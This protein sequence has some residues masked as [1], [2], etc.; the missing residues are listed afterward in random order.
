[1]NADTG[2]YEPMN[3]IRRA[4]R[5]IFPL[6][7][8]AL[9]S[10]CGGGGG[11]SNVGGGDV[12]N[13]V[14]NACGI[15]AVSAAAV[16][17]PAVASAAVPLGGAAL[18]TEPAFTALTFDRPIAMKQVEGDASC[19]FVA[20]QP[21]RV[22]AFENVSDVSK[23]SA[24]I[25]ISDRVDNGP[26]EAGLLGMAFHPNFTNNLQVFLSYTGDNGGQLTSY[27]SRFTSSDGGAT[28]DPD[29]E[30]ILLSLLQPFGNHNGG[31]IAFG[32][33]GYLYIG[34]GDGGAGNDPGERAQNTM[35]LY[36]AMLRIDVDT[37][38]PYAIPG[39][40]PFAGNALC[41]Q[42]FGAADCPE[43]Y[44]WGLRNPWR[45]SFD[46][47]TG[48]LWLGD[49]G[50]SAFEE[51]DIIDLGGNYGWPFFEA[52]LCNQNAPMVDCDF[53]GLLP[54]T[55]YP[56]AV[57]RAVTGGYVYHGN[58]IPD[59][60]GVYVYA[61]Y[62][63]GIVFQYFDSGGG[64]IIES[65]TNTALTISSFGQATDGELYLFDLLNGKIHKL[66]AD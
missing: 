31:N 5:R 7:A 22:F 11:E 32:P 40:N 23:R 10:A 55:E 8:L 47:G 6:L 26:N 12:N 45:W 19:W 35:N 56:R 42:G 15:E 58:D 17:L 46:S 18:T 14:N 61:D 28:L 64:N 50:Q 43:L 4:I 20:E 39:D 25:D 48:D 21:G 16:T 52:T 49:V 66:V 36:G 62:V 2:Y 27:V 60:I 44:A 59:L 9:L 1:M 57:G 65:T 54:V 29:S 38:V 41:S 51:I 63:T 13:Y 34:F 53:I 3:M 33:D 30:E 24:F 37:K